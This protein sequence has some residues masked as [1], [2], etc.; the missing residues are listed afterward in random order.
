MSVFYDLLVNLQRQLR[1]HVDLTGEGNSARIRPE[2]IVLR[3]APFDTDKK[4]WSTN[5][6]TPGIL[7]SPGRT[8]SV[9]ESAGDNERDMILYPVSIQIIDG[10]E[11]GRMDQ[12]C[13]ES[14]L[15]W[16]ENIRKYLNQQNLRKSVWDDAGYV[17]LCTMPQQ[18]QINTQ[19]FAV[20][21]RCVFASFARFHSLESRNLQGRK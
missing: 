15:K 7:V 5:E 8:I 10:G 18:E 19:L 11:T 20:H 21:D 16:Q 14:W 13:L 6:E 2:A 3:H 1:E 12:R 9:D 17:S 4:G